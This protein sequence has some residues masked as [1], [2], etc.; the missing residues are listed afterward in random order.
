M[1]KIPKTD[2]PTT[3]TVIDSV[4]EREELDAAPFRPHLGASQIGKECERELWYGFRG[5]SRRTFPGRILRLFDRGHR[6]EE[7]LVRWLRKTGAIV[8]E[9]DPATGDQ[10]RFRAVGGHFGGSM[11]GCVRGLVESP[12]TW[13]VLEFK[14]SGDKPFRSLAKNGVE[15]AKP[16][17]FAQ[18]QVYMSLSGMR[19]AFYLVV[20]KNDDTLY[21]ERV[22]FDANVAKEMLEKAA[23][24]IR[25]QNPPAK[26][27]DDPTWWKCRFCDFSSTCHEGSL[28]DLHCR[29][30]LH[31]TPET[32]GDEPRWSCAVH[33]RD[34][35][36]DAQLRG[37]ISHRYIP[38]LLEF[39]DTV[40]ANAEKN[41]VEYA[42]HGTD[43]RFRN[44]DLEN[45][46]FTSA[47]IK[48]YGAKVAEREDKLGA[49]LR[50]TFGAR[51]EEE[52]ETPFDV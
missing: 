28:P 5:A 13:H 10:F 17:H 15:K 43:A 7:S 38:S 4:L 39:A 1:P 31:A 50:R 11:D 19:R 30:C 16:E 23:R 12:K 40:D 32:D 21:S 6:E 41:F 20:N 37:C 8:H 25:S 45:G 42:I 33:G 24:I 9:V 44:G 14:T 3:L 36:F 49:E 22:T 18:V 27:S 35:P 29:T 47:D 26:L 48:R 46:G 34:L 52:R 2:K 51:L